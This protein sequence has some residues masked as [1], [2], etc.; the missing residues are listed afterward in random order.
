MF[1][2]CCNFFFFCNFYFIFIYFFYF[3]YFSA[4]NTDGQVAPRTGFF[5]NFQSREIVV[6]KWDKYYEG[7]KLTK[8]FYYIK[9]G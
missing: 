3:F 7:E 2:F 6:R 1:F 9:I 8:S 5:Y 4:C